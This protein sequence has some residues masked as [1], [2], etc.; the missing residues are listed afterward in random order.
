M[1]LLLFVVFLYNISNIEI[2]NKLADKII[3][4]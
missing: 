3:N 4:N 1:E 2:S